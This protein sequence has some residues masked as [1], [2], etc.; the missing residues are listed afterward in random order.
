MKITNQF[1]ISELLVYLT[2]L[3]KKEYAIYHN[4][5]KYFFFVSF[6]V[7]VDSISVYF[8][9]AV[10]HSFLVTKLKNKVKK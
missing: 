7:S 10:Y 2:L 5:Q 9:M 3:I 6:L 1:N 8:Q 4:I